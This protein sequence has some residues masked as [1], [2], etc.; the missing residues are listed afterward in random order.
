VVGFRG[1]GY[2]KGGQAA[3]GDKQDRKIAHGF[4]SF[5]AHPLSGAMA[6]VR[7]VALAAG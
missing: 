6:L 5:S 3:K 7:D 1:G 4:I 2:D